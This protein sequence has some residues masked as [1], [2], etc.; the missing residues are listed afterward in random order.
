MRRGSRGRGIWEKVNRRGV[1]RG[2]E[3]QEEGESGR[4]STGEG[5]QEEKR[6]KRKGNQEEINRRGYQEEKEDQEEGE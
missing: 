4:R 5:Y 1:S 3:D 6:I 2:E